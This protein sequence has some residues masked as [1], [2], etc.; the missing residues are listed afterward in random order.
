MSDTTTLLLP[1]ESEGS[2][3][4]TLLVPRELWHNHYAPTIFNLIENSRFLETFFFFIPRLRQVIEDY[5]LICHMP[6]RSVEFD[7][8]VRVRIEAY[9]TEAVASILASDA[10]AAQVCSTSKDTIKATC[11]VQVNR[12][13]AVERVLW[14]LLHGFPFADI[15]VRRFYETS[16]TRLRLTGIGL[17]VLHALTTEKLSKIIKVAPEAVCGVIEKEV[18]WLFMESEEAKVSVLAAL[19]RLTC[20]VLG[21]RDRPIPRGNADNE[22]NDADDWWDAMLL[23]ASATLWDL[24]LL[25]ADTTLSSDQDRVIQERVWPFLESVL[26]FNQ[27]MSPQRRLH[28][29]YHDLRTFW[30]SYQAVALAS[31]D[32]RMLTHLRDHDHDALYRYIFEQCFTALNPFP[33]ED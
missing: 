7:T 26:V 33:T 19:Y 3:L 12:L 2:L 16:S 24:A 29:W 27:T 31:V 4:Q 23:N 20:L 15:H 22:L 30:F 11:D 8:F 6:E 1:F 10:W 25:K 14:I 21:P 28:K 32:I 5:F 9:E 17:L 18:S 13:C